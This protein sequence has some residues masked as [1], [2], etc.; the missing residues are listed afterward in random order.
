MNFN[1]FILILGQLIVFNAQVWA[2]DL[3]TESWHT[4]PELSGQIVIPRDELNTNYQNRAFYTIS[5]ANGYLSAAGTDRWVYLWRLG[6]SGEPQFL[7]ALKGHTGEVLATAI[8]PDGK[9]LASGS[10]DKSL[11]LWDTSTGSVIRKFPSQVSPASIMFQPGKSHTFA[12]FLKDKEVVIIEREAVIHTIKPGTTNLLSL[13]WSPNGLFLGISGQRGIA[14]WS[15]EKRSIV[16]RIPFNDS[17][18]AKSILLMGERKLFALTGRQLIFWDDFLKAEPRH[19]NL[20]Q[21]CVTAAK[22]DVKRIAI[23]CT[24]GKIRVFSFTS[25]W[26]IDEIPLFRATVEGLTYLPY[27]QLLVAGSYEDYLTTWPYQSQH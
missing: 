6:K 18:M 11:R 3:P 2:Q 7:R 20:A 16:H 12:T 14:I 4:N 23:G 27:A 19:I 15:A 21:T 26:I 25:D 24:D 9:L 1:A 10:Y 17:S 22:I 13:D 5:H 8:S